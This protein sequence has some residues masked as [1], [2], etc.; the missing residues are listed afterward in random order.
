[1]PT[2]KRKGFR[3]YIFIRNW[4]VRNP[5]LNRL[6]RFFCI[7]KVPKADLRCFCLLGSESVNERK[8]FHLN[9]LLNAFGTFVS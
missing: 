9:E 4:D 1:M 5:A 2:I 3:K 8:P 6:A 7:R